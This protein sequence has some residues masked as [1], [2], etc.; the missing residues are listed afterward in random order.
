MKVLIYFILLTYSIHSFALIY[1]IQAKKNSFPFVINL[2]NCTATK[3]GP[4]HFITAAHC[5]SSLDGKFANKTFTA[6]NYSSQ[7]MGSFFPNGVSYSLS[8]T[9][10]VHPTWRKFLKDCTICSGAQSPEPVATKSDVAL[11]IVDELTP[12]IPWINI[13]FDPFPTNDSIKVYLAGY[14]CTANIFAP[15]NVGD[16]HLRYNSSYLAPSNILTH[17]KSQYIG[18]EREAADSNWITRGYSMTGSS[19]SL[20]PGDSGGPLLKINDEGKW[21]IIGIAHNYTFNGVYERGI[22]MTNLHSRLD[23][24]SYNSVGFWIRSKWNLN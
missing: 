21:T 23:D 15:N 6:T 12:L 8:G 17:N 2:G 10:Y 20:C 4:R 13:D 11:Y 3:V 1:G 7:T 5:G 14:G 9:R 24:Y 16:G 19:A 22:S 18:L